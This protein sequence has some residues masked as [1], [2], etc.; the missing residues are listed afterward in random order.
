MSDSIAN[1]TDWVEVLI[2]HA[3]RNP[4]WTAEEIWGQKVGIFDHYW[5]SRQ[6]VSQDEARVI[7]ECPDDIWERNW[8]RL[9]GF[10]FH[11][12]PDLIRKLLY[13]E[14][15]QPPQYTDP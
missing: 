12:D 7:C 6:G 3:N 8:K 1:D 15:V 11:S 13:D 10:H 14:C 4:R 5:T 9:L 2:G